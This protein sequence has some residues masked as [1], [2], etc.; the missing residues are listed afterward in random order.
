M[1]TIKQGNLTKKEF[2]KR[3]ESNNDGGGITN[4]DIANCAIEWRISSRPYTRNMDNIVY[5][6]LK[7]AEVSD[8]E[9]FNP[10][11]FN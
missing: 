2:K 5:Q 9:E 8:A 1:P 4:Q 11:I 10:V 7:A 6:V 3:W